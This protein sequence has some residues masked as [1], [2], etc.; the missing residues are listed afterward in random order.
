MMYVPCCITFKCCTV[1]IAEL[2][3]SGAVANTGGSILSI[4]WLPLP[5]GQEE[6][7]HF[8][9]VSTNRLQEMDHPHILEDQFSCEGVVQVW[10][11]VKSGQV[12]EEGATVGGIISQLRLCVA[13]EFGYVRSLKW[14]P[15]G[16]FVAPGDGDKVCVC[17]CACVCVHV[18]MR[19]CLCVCLHD[20]F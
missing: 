9:A 18:C 16:T 13:H 17:V 20:V 1:Y 12:P 7:T 14:C 6:H 15:S 4:D 11:F 8:L 2:G 10:A 5:H 3:A 19:A